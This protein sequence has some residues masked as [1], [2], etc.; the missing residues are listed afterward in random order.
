VASG[1][2]VLIGIT[3]ALVIVRSRRT[4]SPSSESME[5]D[6]LVEDYVMMIEEESYRRSAMPVCISLDHVDD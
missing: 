1:L 6:A 5:A 4:V 2:L 3:V